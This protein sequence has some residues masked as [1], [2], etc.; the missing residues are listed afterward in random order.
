MH[1]NG[2]PPICSYEGSDYQ[3]RFWDR[4]DRAYEDLI[5]AIAL[6]RLLPRRG[7]RVLELGAGAGRH[8]QRLV[9]YDRVVLLDYARSQLRQAQSRLGD[10]DRYAYVVGDVY[11]L[12]FASGSFDG[13]TMIR[14]LHHLADP[15][16]ALRQVRR[17]LVSQATFVL[18]F[19]NKRNLKAILRWLFRRQGWNPFDRESIE[20]APLNYNFHPASVR[21]WLREAGFAVRRL[22]TVS[23]FRLGWLKRHL[24]TRILVAAD[25]LL[26]WSGRWMQWTPSVFVKA[27]AERDPHP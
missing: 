23:H 25:A 19:A 8:S 9:G 27:I 26:Q 21:A 15:D 24:P 5:E 13:A 1:A 20:F 2:H 12:P 3:E 22:L 17:I 11:R 18:E 7:S 4:G 14:T 10:L 6:R 16:S